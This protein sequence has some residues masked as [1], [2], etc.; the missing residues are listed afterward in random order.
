MNI[1]LAL[2][3][4]LPF[5]SAMLSA[6]TGGFITYSMSRATQR[7]EKRLKG[8]ES[9]NELK[10]LIYEISND[11]IDLQGKLEVEYKRD[12]LF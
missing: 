8:L 6:V 11:A 1:E 4:L 2:K 10:L 3:D 7:K 12:K 9:I 5:G